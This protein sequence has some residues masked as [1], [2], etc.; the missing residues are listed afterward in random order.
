MPRRGSGSSKGSGLSPFAKMG[1]PF[2]P[3]FAPTIH[4]GRLSGARTPK[5]LHGITVKDPVE[6]RHY[7]RTEDLG[8]LNK[9]KRHGAHQKMINRRRLSMGRGSRRF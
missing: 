7:L 5:L 2:A 6:N 9:L 4:V 1:S 3:G 8:L